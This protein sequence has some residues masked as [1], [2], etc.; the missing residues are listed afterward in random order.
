M[1]ARTSPAPRRR[2]GFTLIELLV[3]IAIIAILIGLLLPAVQKVREAAARTKCSNNLKQLGLA[4]HNYHDTYKKFPRNY[5]QV[6]GNVWEAL[7][8]NYFLLP[9]F[10]QAP[11][12]AQG[13]ANKTNWGWMYNNLMNT[14]L[15]VFTC[16]S[17]LQGSQR[18]TNPSG[19]DGPGT[20]Y[21]WCTGSR[22][23][24]VWAGASFNGMIAY[25]VDRRMADA[26]T[27]CQTH[28]WLPRSSP[29]LPTATPTASILTTSSTP[30]TASTRPLPTATSPPWPSWTR[31]AARRGHRRRASARTT[32]PCGPGTPPPNR[33][34]PRPPHRIGSGPARAAI[35]APAAPRLGLRHYPAPQHA[36]GWRQCGP[37]RRLRPF[38]HRFDRCAHLPA[39]RERQ[40]RS[41]D[42]TA[43]IITY[44][45]IRPRGQGSKAWVLSPLVGVEP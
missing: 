6:G 5:L 29:A 24:T 13:E 10:E 12:F 44:R 11:L 26:P 18:G 7:S 4:M 23:E 39:V 1:P 3:V 36:L 32:A 34:S 45:K 9:F 37:R 25:S 43:L 17:S 19:W 2:S 15:A 22:I 41:A 38:R 35:A 27:V 30:T 8:A 40:G 14:K 31:S 21:A 20:N 42:H 33:R 16:P 28:C